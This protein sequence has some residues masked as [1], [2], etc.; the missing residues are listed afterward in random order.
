[1]VSCIQEDTSSELKIDLKTLDASNTSPEDAKLNTSDNVNSLDNSG[2]NVNNLDGEVTNLDSGNPL[3]CSEEISIVDCNRNSTSAECGS[4]GDPVLY[5]RDFEGRSECLWFSGEC[6]A[7]EFTRKCDNYET[8]ECYPA[9]GSE[10]WSIDQNTVIDLRINQTINENNPVSATCS[11]CIVSEDSIPHSNWIDE[12]CF[13][14]EGFCG[15]LLEPLITIYPSVNN[16]QWGWPSWVP[17]LIV[18]SG[19]GGGASLLIEFDPLRRVES[20]RVCLIWTT[21]AGNINL[22]PVCATS[23]VF[24][25]SGIPL[26]QNEIE[27]LHG[28]IDV[29]FPEFSPFPEA[30]PFI[31]GLRINASF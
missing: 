21:D 4:T 6:I 11:E 15:T 28:N 23:G 30:E 7:N 20:A 3:P 1:M 2:S 8:I 26:N 13:I 27:N 9:L 5:C 14:G 29:L 17:I 12:Q 19:I 24:E 18:H 16:S 22:K 10:Q 25:V 31:Q